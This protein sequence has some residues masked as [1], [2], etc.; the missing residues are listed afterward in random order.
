ME[1]NAPTGR[2]GNSQKLCHLFMTD[3]LSQAN[4]T[5]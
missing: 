4:N 5:K 3:I 1:E 2:H